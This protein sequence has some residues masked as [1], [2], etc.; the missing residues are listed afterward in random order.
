MNAKKKQVIRFLFIFFFEKIW[1]TM[2]FI[3]NFVLAISNI[4]F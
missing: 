4:K 1:I 3:S 2:L